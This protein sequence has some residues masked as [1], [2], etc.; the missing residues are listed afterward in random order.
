MNKSRLI[1]L[2]ELFLYGVI[3]VI[4]SSVD[5][6]LFKALITYW[7][8]NYLIVNSI[9]VIAGILIS[10]TLNLYFNFKTFDNILKRFISFFS[11]GIFGMLLSSI[12]LTVGDKLNIDIFIVKLA[13]IVIVAAIQF[14]LNKLLSFRK[15]EKING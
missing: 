8:E 2:K 3:G 15:E 14:V 6:L 13:S 12:I 1:L 7:L 11:V 9:S 5:A 10:F 4:S